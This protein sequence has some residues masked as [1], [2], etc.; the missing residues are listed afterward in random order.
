MIAIMNNADL[1][2]MQLCKQKLNYNISTI[3]REFWCVDMHYIQG[4]KMLAS[5]TLRKAISNKIKNLELYC[6]YFQP[7][8]YTGVSGHGTYHV[9]IDHNDDYLQ[10]Q[11]MCCAQCGSYSIEYINEYKRGQARIYCQCL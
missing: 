4:L 2:V 5:Q 3:I 10:I 6:V 9:G 1:L 11:F 8:S 7:Y